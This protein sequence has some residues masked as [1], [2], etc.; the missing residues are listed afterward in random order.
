MRDCQAI[1]N[2]ELCGEKVIAKDLCWPHYQRLRRNGDLGSIPIRQQM[3]YDSKTRRCINPDCKNLASC[4]GMCKNCYSRYL[5]RGTYVKKA[6]PRT[7]YCEE[8]GC[9]NMVARSGKCWTHYAISR[10]MTIRLVIPLEVPEG[11]FC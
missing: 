8:L 9:Y 2:G 10:K 1:V 11:V 3:K 4:R 7:G 5:R 6:K